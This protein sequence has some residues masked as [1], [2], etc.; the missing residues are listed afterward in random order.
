MSTLKGLDTWHNFVENKNYEDFSDFIDDDAILYSPI[1]FRPIKGSFMVGMYLMA[2]AEIIG[3]GSFKYVREVC[4]NENAIL[5]FETEINGITVEG[6]DMI[7]F[8][9][10]GKLKEIKVMVRPLQA[11]NVVHEKMGEYLKKMNS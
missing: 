6:V 10:D 1:V 11:V 7:Q 9:K 5:E 4:D 3:N 2:A 8:T